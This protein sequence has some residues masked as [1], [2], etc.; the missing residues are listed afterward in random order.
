MAIRMIFR[1]HEDDPTTGIIVLSAP[2]AESRKADIRNPARRLKSLYVPFCATDGFSN[3]YS[4]EGCNNSCYGCNNSKKR[5]FSRMGYILIFFR[6]LEISNVAL[7]V[8]LM[9]HAS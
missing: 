6:Q 9:V 8:E 4:S 1:P 3:C 2:K 7:L 5:M